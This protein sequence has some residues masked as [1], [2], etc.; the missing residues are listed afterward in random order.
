MLNYMSELVFKA[1][2]LIELVDPNDSVKL[3][4]MSIN[5]NDIMCKSSFKVDCLVEK[6]KL[7]VVK[8]D[9]LY[10]MIPLTVTKV[11]TRLRNVF[12]NLRPKLDGLTRYMQ[13]YL[14]QHAS[15][16]ERLEAAKSQA[17][18]KSSKVAADDA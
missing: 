3:M 14:Q 2:S 5:R 15:V 18:V 12:I 9:R 10:L 13:F 16:N 17:S 8:C 11:E 6:S 4:E 1:N 7:V